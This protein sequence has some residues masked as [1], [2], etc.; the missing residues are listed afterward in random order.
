[1]QDVSIIY[2]LVVC[3][4]FQ[5]C[6]FTYS[7]CVDI[8]EIV[9]KRAAVALINGET[10]WHMHRPLPESCTVDFLHFNMPQPASANKVFWRTCSFLLGATATVAFKDKINVQL[11][12]FPSPNGML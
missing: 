5:C 6:I 1:M 11:H 12:S 9:S 8:G 3:G 7:S 10:L 2:V 4:I